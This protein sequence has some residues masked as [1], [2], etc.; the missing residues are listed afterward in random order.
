MAESTEPSIT[1]AD[2]AAGLRSRMAHDDVTADQ[3]GE[4]IGWDVTQV[5]NDPEVLWSYDVDGMYTLARAAGLDWVA[6]LRNV[7]VWSAV[8]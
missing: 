6:L 8:A 5:I 4:M 1:F 2:I 3:L 7:K